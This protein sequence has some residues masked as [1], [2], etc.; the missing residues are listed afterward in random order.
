M[1]TEEN[2]LNRAAVERIWLS[3]YPAGVPADIDADRFS[4]IKQVF[5]E[6]CKNY[7]DLPAFTCMDKSLTYGALDDMS[8]AFAA[9]LQ[10]VLKLEK[11][12]RVAVMMPNILQYPVAI[13]GILRAGFTVVNVNP[14]YTPRELEHQLHDSGAVAIVVVE[15][16]AATL[17]QVLGKTSI[18]QVISTQIGDLLGFPKSL[19]TNFVIKHKKK[20]VPGW[21]IPGAISFTAAMA[22]GRRHK[23]IE[24]NVQSGDHAF[25]QYTGGTTG[26]SKG[27]VLTHRNLIA[28]I[29]QL[30]AWI[31]DSLAERQEI[32]IQPLPMYHIYA[33]STS[34]FFMRYGCETVLIPN[35]RDMAG[36]VQVMANRRWTVLT[37]VNTLFNSLINNAEFKKLDFSSTKLCL[38][39]GMAVQRV[40]AEQWQQI[41]GKPLVEG[42]GLTETSPS[43]TINR[44]DLKTYSGSIG[45]PL[46][47]TIVTIRDDNETIL[48]TGEI[49]EICIDGPQVMKGYWQRDDETAKVMTRDGAFKTGDIGV[50]DVHGYIKI[51][52]RK[53]D[54]IL[55]SG[56]N[57][58]PNEI[59]DVVAACPGV[60]EVCAVSAADE[61]SGEVVRVVIVKKDQALTKAQVL[62]YCKANLTGY[63]VPKIVE[64]WDELPK[65]NVGKVLRRTVRD[66]PAKNT[67]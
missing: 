29:Q 4:S 16:V 43:A 26:I 7:R 59:E 39:G 22:Q 66:T 34:V 65:T 13:C 1:D 63:K 30:T 23:F 25:L 8:R 50:M 62:D 27:A 19:L 56:F 32:V 53:K 18:K 9:Y 57:V 31:G 60:L 14:L 2:R 47:S 67:Q 6:A 45:L 10:N 46:P 64:F 33:L 61:K 41:T 21:H 5:D 49:G 58:Y 44:L 35:P 38:G 52:D 54:M 20:M 12:D 3:S 37:G 11:G 28:N 40:V 15:N 48:A 17:Q 42:Y 55:V 24:P 36:F 51:V